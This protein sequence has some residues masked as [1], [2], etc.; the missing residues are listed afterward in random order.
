MAATMTPLEFVT[1]WKRASVSEHQAAQSHFNDI[2]A[3]IGEPTPI[4]ADPAGTWYAFEA[5]VIKITGGQ[6]RADVWRRGCF[7]W[8]Y[9]GKD[10]DLE[11]A[12]QQLLQYR[13]GLLNPPLL[14]VSDIAEIRI[15]TNFTNTVHKTYRITLDD[16]LKPE[17]VSMLRRA[18]TA[19]DSFKAPLTTEQVTEKAAAEFARLAQLLVKWGHEPHEVAH[20]LIRILFCLFAEDADL[21][22]EGLFA[23]LVTLARRRAALFRPQLTQLF[24]AMMEGGTFGVD[25]IKHFNGGLFDNVA[26]LDMPSD[27]L[28]IV[29]EVAGLDWSSI[30]PSIFGTLFER[31]LDP[32]KRSQ[33]GA[34]YT[35]REDILLIVEPVLMAPLRKRWADVQAQARDMAARRDAASGAKRTRLS[36]D[37]FAMLRGFRNELAGVRVL[38]AA[39]GSGNFLYVALRLL[40]DLEKEVINLAQALGDS[41]SFPFVSPEQLHGIEINTYAHELAQVTV[42]IGYIQ[43][44][45]E[46]GFG[47]PG[48]PILKPLHNILNMD[49][50][51]DYD[52][53]GNPVEPE[54]PA[55]DVIIGNPPFL[56]DKKMRSQLGDRY[57][58]DLRKLYEG[59][60]PGGADF[61]TYWFERARALIAA[62]KLK[63]AGLL[64]TQSIRAGANREVLQR[65][66]ST[67]DIF[68]GQADRPWI[69]EGAAVRVS[70]VGFDNGSEL[71]RLLNEN[72]DDQSTDALRNCQRV[73]S[74]NPNLTASANL[75]LAQ[76]LPENRHLCFQGPVKVGSF[77]L[78][79]S[80]AQAMLRSPNPN[81]MPNSTVVKP[82]MN[83]SDLTG[84]ARGMWI[85][86]FGEMDLEVACLYE[87]PFEY[88]QKNV[89]PQRDDNRDRQR[90]T[91]WWRLGRSGGDF[92]KAK[93][94][95]GR[96]I[97]TPRVARHRLFVWA[98]LELV[99]DSRLFAFS[100]DDDYFFGI[101][102]SRLHEVWSLA[103]SSRHG[104][105]N[106]PTYNN[107]TCF[108][109][110]PFPWPPGQEPTDDPR[111]QAI[112]AA[113][114]ELVRLRDN[115]LN[116]PGASEAELKKRTLT[117]LYNERPTWLELAHR[118][119]DGAVMDAYGWPHDLSDDEILARLLTL[120]LQRAGVATEQT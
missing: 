94:N 59:R 44:Y 64:A 45:R 54:W 106:D 34:H 41:G 97:V 90:R 75:T 37:L 55:A 29:A 2:C 24:Q 39:C 99:P 95:L 68:Y 103:T 7:A 82:W 35:S 74:I 120:N 1:K 76:R 5:N 65:I 114:A 101:L 96:V 8:E 109:T 89:K 46:N 11:K 81:N 87:A 113:A 102:H 49:A 6:G 14:I 85:I 28:D 26:V 4:E 38:D 117:N 119:L 25:E 17:M 33:L 48:E 50:V 70:M 31:S 58:D 78:D 67:G 115:W 9:K 118:K 18:F 105:G 21:L 43:W 36:N 91:Y 93:S 107:T 3:L 62:G 88:V 108:E 69:N 15:H 73:S 47:T 20:F 77:E 52:E 12:Y 61:V 66:K 57:V 32:S 86:D 92:K 56:G 112:A 40:L 110:Y 42:W 13:D 23:R 27:A 79:D 16:L 83:A 116:P 10:G 22:P 30:E 60:V 72:K 84:R 63:R 100:R 111:V 71:E 19:P 80:T 51:L 104:V 98:P 53:Q